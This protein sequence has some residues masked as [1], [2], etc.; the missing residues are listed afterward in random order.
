MRHS[1]EVVAQFPYEFHTAAWEI[2]NNREHH[3]SKPEGYLVAGTAM[4]NAH[5]CRRSQQKCKLRASNVAI[6]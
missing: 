1:L 5:P 4:N 3:M 6:S 2:H